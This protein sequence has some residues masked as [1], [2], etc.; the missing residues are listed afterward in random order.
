M[1]GEL[2]VSVKP[3]IGVAG[4]EEADCVSHRSMERVVALGRWVTFLTSRFA[5]VLTF[6]EVDTLGEEQKDRGY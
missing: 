5:S 3:T 1:I 2:L 6:K 4:D